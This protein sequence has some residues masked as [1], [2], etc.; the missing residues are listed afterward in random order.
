MATWEPIDIDRDEIDFEDEYDKTDTIDDANLDESMTTLNEPIREQEE[1]LDRLRK[2]EWTSINEDERRK[3]K[4]Q[5]A[6]QEKEQDLYIM[7]ASKTIL[8]ILHKGFSEIKQGGRVM[9]S[10]EKAAKKLY[11]PLYLEKSDGDTYKITSDT[12]KGSLKD[13]LSTSN[14]WLTFNGYL[15][16]FGKKFIKNMTW[17]NQ[18]AEQKVRFLRRETNKWNSR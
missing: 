11:D 5:I 18:K 6:F 13:L 17:I 4:Q 10:D 15:K 9:V 7:R 16:I 12:E 1:L 8:T 2:T 3:L 14:N